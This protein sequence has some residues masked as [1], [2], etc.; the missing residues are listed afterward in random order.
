[1][2]EM[3]GSPEGTGEFFYYFRS[4]KIPD[5]FSSYANSFIFTTLLFMSIVSEY[6]CI[7]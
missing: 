1:M 6:K 5:I 7:H 2:N 3:N 4:E